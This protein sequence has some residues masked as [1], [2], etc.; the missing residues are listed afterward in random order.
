M[1]ADIE[2]GGRDNGG[3]CNKFHIFHFVRCLRPNL[4][5][6]VGYAFIFA[7]LIR[8]FSVIQ[9][10]IEPPACRVIIDLFECTEIFLNSEEFV[11]IMRQ[12]AFFDVAVN[13]RE[14]RDVQ[15]FEL[16]RICNLL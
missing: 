9:G 4:S 1:L 11:A 15:V 8:F 5:G 16:A 6:Q 2:I 7:L 14:F 10:R 3:R 13:H 12:Y